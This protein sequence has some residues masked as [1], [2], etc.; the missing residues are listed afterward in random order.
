MKKRL[1]FLISIFTT[2]L[3]IGGIFWYF[4]GSEKNTTESISELKAIEILKNQFSEFKDYPSDNLPPKS[5]KTE[6]AENGWYVAFV[7]EG[8]GRPIIDARCFLVKNDGKI[9]QKKYDSQADTSVGEFSAKECTL[10]GGAVG[11]N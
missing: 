2:T 11:G 1:L 3:C 5:I 10:I 8:S 6:K 9:I 4:N 7:Q